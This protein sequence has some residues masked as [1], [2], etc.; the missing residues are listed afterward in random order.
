MYG[1]VYWCLS[2]RPDPFPV[3]INYYNASGIDFPVGSLV[4]CH[5]TLN[6]SLSFVATV[7]ASSTADG[8]RSFTAKITAYKQNSDAESGYET[9][10]AVCIIAPDV[11]WG[12]NET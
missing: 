1:T 3:R 8:C 10:H 5:D 4:F 7:I 6:A 9:F 11:R 2:S 12:N